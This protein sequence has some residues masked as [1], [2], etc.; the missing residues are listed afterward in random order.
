M[1]GLSL[2]RAGLALA[3]A[4]ALSGAACRAP[5]ATQ[6]P[7][8][9][10][11]D[12]VAIELAPVSDQAKDPALAAHLQRALQKHLAKASAPA[13]APGAAPLRVAGALLKSET[14]RTP[15]DS[16][17][18]VEISLT[19][20]RGEEI[21]GFLSKDGSMTYTEMISVEREADGRAKVI[22]A[23]VENALADFFQNIERFR[24]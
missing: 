22:D 7:A 24:S 3:L 18:V 5:K 13:D 9:F 15:S 17:V 23:L 1:R 20:T 11:V 2:L 8:R 10:L 6:T 4:V 12:G 21:V 16:T 14:V 19:F